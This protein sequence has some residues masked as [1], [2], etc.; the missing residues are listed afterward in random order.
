MESRRALIVMARAYAF[1]SL[2]LLAASLHFHPLFYLRHWQQNP[3]TLVYCKLPPQLPLYCSISYPVLKFIYAV[4][5][6]VWD[7][8][9]R[10][11]SV[12]EQEG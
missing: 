1:P 5:R 8:A 12:T 9:G 2:P 6:K 3:F 10:A 4:V 7:Q 11:A